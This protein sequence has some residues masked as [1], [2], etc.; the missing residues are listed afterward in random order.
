[1]QKFIASDQFE[2]LWIR[3]NAQIQQDLVKALNGDQTGAVTVRDGV[4][5]LDLAVVAEAVQQA[6]VDRGLTVF[7]NLP[8][9]Q[10]GHEIVLLSSSQLDAA[11]TVWTFTD[12]IARWLLPIVFLLYLAAILLAPNRRRM[13]LVSGLVDPRGHGPAGRWPSTSCGRSTSTPSTPAASARR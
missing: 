2:A 7:A 10:T 11:Q 3:V 8:I 1:M 13:L 9:P 12:P 4:V 6:L 5:Y